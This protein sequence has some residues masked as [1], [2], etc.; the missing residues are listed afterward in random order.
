MVVHVSKNDDINID[1][2]FYDLV[3]YL[4]TSLEGLSFS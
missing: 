1:Y 2:K 3:C 4:D